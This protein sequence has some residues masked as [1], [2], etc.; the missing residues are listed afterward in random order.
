MAPPCLPLCPSATAYR[1]EIPDGR[2]AR[3]DVRGVAIIANTCLTTGAGIGHDQQCPQA[4]L[5]PAAFAFRRLGFRR[6]GCHRGIILG[7]GQREQAYPLMSLSKNVA[8]RQY[9]LKLCH[10]RLSHVGFSQ[11]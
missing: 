9:F 6:L 4:E 7:R 10:S 5:K 2:P 1:R 11:I 3:R 8:V